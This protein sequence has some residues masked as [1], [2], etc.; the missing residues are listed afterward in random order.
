[1]SA[2]ESAF[3]RSGRFIVIMAIGASDSTNRYSYCFIASPFAGL[4]ENFATKAP[5]HKAARSGDGFELSPQCS[6]AA[7]FFSPASM[8]K[9]SR[10]C[11]GG[12][13]HVANF[14]NAQGGL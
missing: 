8:R 14:V 3:R 11:R 7:Y 1:M 6:E 12:N 10:F 5:R 13:G 9:G 2:S 4:S